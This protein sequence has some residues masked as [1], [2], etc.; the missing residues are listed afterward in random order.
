M[1]KNM[2]RSLSLLLVSVLL[3]GALCSCGGSAETLTG[4]FTK[5]DVGYFLTENGAVTHKSS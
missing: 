4:Y 3:V 2:K 5:G 1:E